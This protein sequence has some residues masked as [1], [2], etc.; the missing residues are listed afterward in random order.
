M[1]SEWLL[2][3]ELLNILI[4]FCE[5]KKNVWFFGQT[6]AKKLKDKQTDAT[7]TEQQLKKKLL[8]IIRTGVAFR[9]AREIA[10]SKIYYR[11][12][13]LTIILIHF[14]TF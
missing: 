9:D 4:I 1:G 10:R 14:I 11:A 13:I 6:S 8:S 5:L 2:P 7:T 12:K 3:T